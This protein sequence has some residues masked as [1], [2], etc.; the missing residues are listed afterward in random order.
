TS[1]ARAPRA[2]RSSRRG[3][4]WG[5]CRECRVPTLLSSAPLSF[6]PSAPSSF[7]ISAPF[8][9]STS[10][11]S[12]ST[13]HLSRP[14]CARLCLSR[15]T[16]APRPLTP[17]PLP[18]SPV[19]PPSYLPPRAIA[20]LRSVLAA[21]SSVSLSPPPIRPFIPRSSCLVS[22]PLR[23]V[24]PPRVPPSL[25]SPPSFASPPSPSSYHP[26]RVLTTARDPHVRCRRA[27]LRAEEVDTLF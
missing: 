6:S 2:P 8:S 18:A 22:R 7:C 27:A 15:S 25:L 10:S 26:R 5:I 24:L 11:L 23:A 14:P 17:H 16:A 19:T 20:P 21:S 13:A 9:F 1:S 4:G 3:F 12:L